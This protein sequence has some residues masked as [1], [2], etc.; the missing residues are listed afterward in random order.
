MQCGSGDRMGLAFHKVLLERLLDS[1][2]ELEMQSECLLPGFI[3]KRQS[4]RSA[5]IPAQD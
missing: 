1:S 4:L 3:E 2:R 5:G